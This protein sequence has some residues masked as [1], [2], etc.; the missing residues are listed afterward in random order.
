MNEKEIIDVLLRVDRFAKGYTCTFL[1]DA[2]CWFQTFGGYKINTDEDYNFW[3]EAIKNITGKSPEISAKE[4]TKAKALVDIFNTYG[5]GNSN[6]TF[7][8][9]QE[10]A[11]LIALQNEEDIEKYFTKLKIDTLN[12]SKSSESMDEEL[13]R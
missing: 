6:G 7:W 2:G 4:N 3:V 13:E 8:I 1:I 10:G 11:K 12:K 9:V 5:I